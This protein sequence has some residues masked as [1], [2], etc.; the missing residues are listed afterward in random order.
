MLFSLPQLSDASEVLVEEV[1]AANHPSQPVL[2][3]AVE[4]LLLLTLPQPLDTQE[5]QSD[6][7][8]HPH[9]HHQLSED[10]EEL[11]THLPVPEDNMI[12][13]STEEPPKE[14]MLEPREPREVT[15]EPKELKEVMLEL[16]EDN[17][18]D[19]LEPPFKEP[20]ED[21][22]EPSKEDKSLPKDTPEPGPQSLLEELTTKVQL[23]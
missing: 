13:E 15:P 4:L 1:A 11:L 6:T 14:D 21:T 23:P 8:P 9:H 2:T 7:L 12:P 17:K 3:H 20:K 16:R 22:P 10:S 19:M 5:L 18:E